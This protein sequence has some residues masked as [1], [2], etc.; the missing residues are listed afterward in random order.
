MGGREWKMQGE[1]PSPS[2]SLS[3]TPSCLVKVVLFEHVFVA[4]QYINLLRTMDISNLDAP[5]DPNT[6]RR[7]NNVP[8][9]K[10]LGTVFAPWSNYTTMHLIVVNIEGHR[11]LVLTRIF[12]IA[13]SRRKQP[14][15]R[16]G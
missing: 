11:P 8:S 2:S 14:G 7:G 4:L 13:R 6:P 9:R 1:A 15:R 12:N 10:D 3:C 5:G 16:S